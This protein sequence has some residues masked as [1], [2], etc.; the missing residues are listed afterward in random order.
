MDG[1]FLGVGVGTKKGW[2]DGTGR[3]EQSINQA[4]IK[5][6]KKKEKRRKK[7]THTHSS[8]TRVSIGS[9]S[10]FVVSIF[11]PDSQPSD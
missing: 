4:K 9:L 5:T 10:A 2:E 11:P 3:P 7:K 8:N 6:K 1:F